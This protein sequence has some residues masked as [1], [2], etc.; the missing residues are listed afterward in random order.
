V[1]A[2][3]SSNPRDESSDR[4]A[5]EVRGLCVSIDERPVLRGLDLCVEPGQVLAVVGASGSGKTM[6]GLAMLDLLPAGGRVTGGHAW[7]DGRAIDL[8]IASRPGGPADP[9]VAATAAATAPISRRSLRGTGIAMIF[10]QPRASL[11]PLRTIAAQLRETVRRLRGPMPRAAADAAAIELLELAGFPRAAER[12]GARPHE[13]S[14]GECQRIMI[15]LA[16]AGR[17]RVLFA[18]EPTTALD[19]LVQG[20]LLET[21]RRLARELRMAVVFVTHDLRV[22]AE[23][24]DAAVVLDAGRTVEA[25][26]CERLFDDPR[27]PATRRLMEASGLPVPAVAAAGDAPDAPGPAARWRIRGRRPG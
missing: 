14:G 10:Q 15:A 5:L 1:T 22:V 24:A 25:A 26:S 8:G 23:V 18:D 20:R 19:V 9:A 7:L 27:H 11:H 2:A 12:L 6:S 17:P 16:L 13:L 21:L 3:P 4:P